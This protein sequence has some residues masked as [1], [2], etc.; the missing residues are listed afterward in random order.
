MS[1]CPKK[2]NK[3][4]ENNNNS[5][6]ESE[7]ENE[8]LEDNRLYITLA[9]EV[10]KSMKDLEDQPFKKTVHHETNDWLSKSSGYF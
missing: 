10:S 6:S 3:V 5:S 4:N 7:D 1:D 8:K 9:F 2:K